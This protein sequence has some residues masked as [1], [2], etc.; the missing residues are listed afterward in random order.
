MLFIWYSQGLREEG[1]AFH[2]GNQATTARLV[3]SFLAFAIKRITQ[4]DWPMKPDLIIS[5]LMK[6]GGLRGGKAQITPGRGATTP[7][8]TY[9]H[10]S[11][12]KSNFQI[13]ACKNY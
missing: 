13:F 5:G 3:S 11:L 12:L 8:H 6:W 7:I 10:P 1:V 2:R 4:T 9:S